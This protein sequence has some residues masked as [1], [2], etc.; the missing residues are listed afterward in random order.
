[1]SRKRRADVTSKMYRGLNL[2]N[3]RMTILQKEADYEF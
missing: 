3:G 2:G 1:M